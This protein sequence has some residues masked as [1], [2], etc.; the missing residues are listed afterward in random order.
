M[1]RLLFFCLFLFSC[2]SSLTPS[3]PP[4]SPAADRC[5]SP[6]VS[7][8]IFSIQ[9]D[10]ADV[11]REVR[12]EFR[13]EGPTGPVTFF[14]SHS[15]KN[16]KFS[17]V[18]FQNVQ[19]REES[20]DT[21]SGRLISSAFTKKNQI[22]STVVE[23]TRSGS[24]Y[25]REVTSLS[26]H[27]PS[28]P[29]SSPS[30]LVLSGNEVFG[31][32]LAEYLKKKVLFSGRPSTF[33]YVDSYLN[34]PIHILAKAPTPSSI[35]VEGRSIS[36][37]FIDVI[38]SDRNVIVSRYF[39]DS[40]GSLIRESY[41]EIHETRTL[42]SGSISLPGDTSELLVGLRS[43]AYLYDPDMATDAV[44]ELVSS[45]D[46][47]DKLDI[48]S[49]SPLQTSKRVSDNTMI[50]RVSSGAP[51]IDPPKKADLASSYY[52]RPDDRTIGDAL[53][54][55][56]SAGKKGSLNADRRLN[57][58]SI[59]AQVSLMK[60]R[61]KIWSDPNRSAALIMEYAHTLLPDKRHT[62]SMS[63]AV[64]TLQNGSGD[65][66]EHAVLFA[67]LMRAHLIPTRLVTGMLLTP[68]G[69][70]AY[71]MW[72]SYF[73]GTKW[74]SIDPS[75]NTFR[76]GALYVAIGRGVSDFQDIRNRLADFMWR[77]FVGVSFNLVEAANNGESLTLAKPDI[78][79]KPIKNL[80]ETVLLNAAVLSEKG[81]YS[82]ALSTVDEYIPDTSRTIK[83]KL[84][85]IQLMV[86][87]KEYSSALNSI[88]SLRGE[89][90]LAEN[91]ILLDRFELEC[92][93]H[94]EQF[95]SAQTTLDRLLSSAVDAYEKDLLTSEF[96]FYSGK[97]EEALFI[98]RKTA[99]LFPKD[100]RILS[101]FALYVSLLDHP[102]SEETVSFAVESAYRVVGSSHYSISSDMKSLAVLLFKQSKFEEAASFIDHALILSPDDGDLHSFQ[103][104]FS[105]RASCAIEISIP[106]FAHKGQVFSDN[107]IGLM[108]FM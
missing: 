39:F 35:V 69:T 72:N 52:I 64:T 68:G 5:T 104:T 29:P 93:L 50:L 37:N 14:L 75:R 74:H 91:T 20:T 81:A 58:T 44:Y 23:V 73:D 106:P 67:S 92:F 56:T 32:R 48:L 65:C 89:T 41:P 102:S 13:K 100:N 59:I 79:N 98:L 83:V 57:A 42:M 101:I 46:N 31:F 21:A 4:S 45:K 107:P 47:L 55:L 12:T 7:H 62:F 24:S 53:L 11:G 80:P 40:D 28:A 9:I 88:S 6:V 99:S 54:Y 86:N 26:S 95:R 60:G 19:I 94:L 71:H 36:G 70:W 84:L 87:A 85:R 18:Y 15:S 76:P 61:S 30:T 78:L 1:V 3:V 34:S 51:D 66:T 2:G 49:E 25:V 27:I 17:S 108:T 82:R 63:D 103:K 97:T 33:F 8:R 77:S 90:S 38:D 105:S 96:L 43:N 10:G 16:E 22:E